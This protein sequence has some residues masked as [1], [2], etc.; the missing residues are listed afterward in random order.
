MATIDAALESRSEEESDAGSLVDFICEGSDVSS[1]EEMEDSPV[2][3][4]SSY[5][6]QGGLRRSTRCRAEPQRYVDEHFVE[7]MTEDA[8]IED[9]LE[10]DSVHSVLSASSTIESEQSDDSDYEAGDEEDDGSD[11]DSPGSGSPSD[12]EYEDESAQT[13]ASDVDAE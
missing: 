1:N 4:M 5:V 11:Y 8:A 2:E 10:C 9:V 6:L 3:L 12:S 7:L 13:S